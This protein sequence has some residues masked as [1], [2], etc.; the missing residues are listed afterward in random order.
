MQI[1]LHA[2]VHRTDEGRL[3]K[4]LLKNAKQFA[5]QG[6]AV[7][8]V[9]RYRRL[10]RDATKK[11]AASAA[12]AAN[13]REV[14]LDALLEG[15]ERPDRMILSSSTLM[16]NAKT[17]LQRG[18]YYSRAAERLEAVQQLFAGDQLELYLSVRNPASFLPAL[19]GDASPSAFDDFLDGTDP[20]ALRWSEM[21]LRIRSM[22]PDVP[23]TVWCNEDT[24]LIWGQIMRDMGNIFPGTK[25]NGSFDLLQEIMSKEGMRRFRTYLK[26][27]P[28]MTEM[29]KRRVMV[30]FLDKFA[31][32][33]E[34]EEELDLP[35][36][37]DELVDELTETYEEDCFNLSRI[38]GVTVIAP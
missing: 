36:W 7:P 37:T 19:Y 12:P 22:L 9:G 32:E 20:R 18:V 17:V 38:P 35:G 29:Q 1:V 26:E 28:G 10:L 31:I 27:H 30:A 14:M 33:D 23:V 4:S 34:I 3:V 24:P 25:I 15:E 21:V 2:G 11:V 8:P 6:V 16:A 13:A 5:E